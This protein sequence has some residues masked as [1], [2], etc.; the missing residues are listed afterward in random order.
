MASSAREGRETV[1][2]LNDLNQVFLPARPSLSDDA[3]DEQLIAYA[4]RIAAVTDAFAGGLRIKAAAPTTSDARLDFGAFLSLQNLSPFV[5]SGTAPQAQASLNV[6]W[7][8]THGDVYL[9]W[10]SDR[11]AV[12]RGDDQHEMAF[13]DQWVADRLAMLTH[14]QSV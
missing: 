9:D 5:V 8:N 3:T 6:L 12:L 13:S 10:A 7:Q 4:G 1:A 14:P 2:L 11:Q